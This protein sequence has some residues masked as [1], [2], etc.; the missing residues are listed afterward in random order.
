MNLKRSCRLT[1]LTQHTRR[2]N[3]SVGKVDSGWT[4]ISIDM[5][6]IRTTSTMRLDTLKTTRLE[7]GFAQN[8][9]TGPLVAPGFENA[10]AN[11]AHGLSRIKPSALKWALVLGPHASPRAR[12]SHQILGGEHGTRGR[13]RSQHQ[14]SLCSGALLKGNFRGAPCVLTNAR[15]RIYHY[16]NREPDRNGH[17]SHYF[18]SLLWLIRY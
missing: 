13:V 15:Q 9:A 4:S 8:Q 18:R 5:S 11:S 12:L 10:E 7:P 6:E 1:S 3:S 17:L 2:I 16:D 14:H